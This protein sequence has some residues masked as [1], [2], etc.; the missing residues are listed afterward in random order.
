MHVYR[1]AE[2]MI[3]TREAV[4]ISTENAHVAFLE[5]AQLRGEARSEAQISQSLSGSY[6]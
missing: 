1:K 4:V 6:L 5:S 2:V 3:S